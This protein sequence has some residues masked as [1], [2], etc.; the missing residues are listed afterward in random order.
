MDNRAVIAVVTLSILAISNGLKR[1]KLQLFY[2]WGQ[3]SG[4]TS[5]KISFIQAVKMLQSSPG[6]EIF[7]VASHD[8]LLELTVNNFDKV[9]DGIWLGNEWNPHQQRWEGPFGEP[10]QFLN[11]MVEI[12]RGVHCP[13]CCLY[14]KLATEEGFHPIIGLSNCQEANHYLALGFEREFGDRKIEAKI[15]KLKEEVGQ[16]VS[17]KGPSIAVSLDL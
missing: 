5:I 14:Y 11:K 7:A 13:I 3:N 6:F 16:L 12:T 10:T 4:M 8:D 17:G 1:R 15:I 9:K 2:N